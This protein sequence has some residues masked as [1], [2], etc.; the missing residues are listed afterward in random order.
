MTVLEIVRS[1]CGIIGLP[2]PSSLTGTTDLQVIQLRELLNKE[3]E[4]L[5]ERSS[6]GC[7]SLV[8]E[9]TFSTVAL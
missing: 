7:E 4:E 8:A 3:G 5:A 9:A 6:L 1:V 2:Q